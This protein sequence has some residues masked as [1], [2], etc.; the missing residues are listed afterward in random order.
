MKL[1]ITIELDGAAFD[2]GNAAFEVATQCRRV[3]DWVRN[4]ESAPIMDA[5]HRHYD[6]D[7]TIGQLLNDSGVLLLSDV[8]GNSCGDARVFEDQ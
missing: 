1:V 4:G 2:D 3:T 8:N 6:P 5:D 7:M